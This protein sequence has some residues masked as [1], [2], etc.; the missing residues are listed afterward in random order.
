M[1]TK[2]SFEFHSIIRDVIRNFWII[3]CA[4]LVGIMGTFVMNNLVYTP[5][6][7]ADASLI[8]NSAAGKANAAAAL[9]QSIQI[10]KIYEKVFVQDSVKE[11]VSEYL[12]LEEFDGTVT[13]AVNEGTNIMELTVKASSPSLAYRELCGILAVYPEFTDSLFDNGAVSI[14][15]MPAVPKSPTNVVS[16]AGLTRNAL[17]A[18]AVGFAAIVGLSVLRNTVKSENDFNSKINSK[19]LATIPHEIKRMSFKDKIKGKK[20]SIIISENIGISL[21]FVES[22]N[23]LVAKMQFMHHKFGYRIF[24]VTSYDEN[25]GKSTIAA[26]IAIALAEK[27]KNVALIDMDVKKP[28]L[29]KVLSLPY[30]EGTEFGDLLS[31]K[32]E[33]SKYRFVRYKRS[34]L[35]VG[36]N[37]KQHNEYPE[38]F[39]NNRLSK[40]FQTMCNDVDYI[41][42]DT[43]PVS[44]DSSAS[45]I[46][47]VCDAT[48]LVVRTD[49]A[50]ADALNDTI[51][52]LSSTG[53]NVV[54]CILND[55]YNPPSLINQMGVDESGYSGVGIHRYGGHYGNYS[56]YS[57]YSKYSSYE[58]Y[59]H[60]GRDDDNKEQKHH[61]ER[62]E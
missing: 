15:K 23:K 47:A 37:E 35:I 33:P 36:I 34:K 9:T 2:I 39:H 25:E 14:L 52:T 1:N 27:G 50:Y 51:Q 12:G 54:G 44:V 19:L 58:N 57:R 24:C 8:I 45:S 26:N 49:I 61:R 11:K 17:L 18:S 7:R 60:F 42:I 21:K 56:K 4:G 46:A 10:A 6:Y 22:F 53:A 38:W 43:A 20:Q 40:I 28:A 41:I 31:G 48:M 3:I 16:S 32:I 30:K 59:S 5:T 29:H 13:A 62:E 55:C